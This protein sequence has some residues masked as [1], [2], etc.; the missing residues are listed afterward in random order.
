MGDGLALL[1][2]DPLLNALHRALLGQ[3]RHVTSSIA[4]AR[5]AWLDRAL[6]D[7]QGA[8]TGA[9]QRALLIDPLSIDRL[10]TRR[11]AQPAGASPLAGCGPAGSAA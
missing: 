1:A 6:G 8:L 3:E 7:G 5:A 10:H 2:A 11:W 9:Q 4:A